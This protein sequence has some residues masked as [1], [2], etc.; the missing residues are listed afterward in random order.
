MSIL[1]IERQFRSWIKIFL[2]IDTG[3]DI[4]QL[5]LQTN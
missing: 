2:K 5:N 1:V 3:H 4:Y